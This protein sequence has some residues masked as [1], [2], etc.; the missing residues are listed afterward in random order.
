MWRVG[1]CS[2]Q[3]VALIY[4]NALTLLEKDVDVR[5]SPSPLYFFLK[6]GVKVNME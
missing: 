5:A 3:D 1:V 6:N 4:L 2:L